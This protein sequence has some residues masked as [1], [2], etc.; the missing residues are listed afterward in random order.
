MRRLRNRPTEPTAP[1]STTTSAGDP[2]IVAR[3]V[4]PLLA[5]RASL[6]TGASVPDATI[7]SAL[8]AASA[9]AAETETPHRDGL[10]AIESTMAGKT[11][12]AAV[13]AMRTTQTQIGDISDRGPA[14]L[15]VL[16][17]AQSTSSRAAKKVDQIIADFRSDAKVI[18]NN[19]NSSPDTDAVI[20]RATQALRDAIGTVT[21]ARTEMDDHTR[22]L[23]SMDP[24]TVTT[25]AG[26]ERNGYGTSDQYGTG[27]GTGYGTGTG[28]VPQAWSPQGQYG[29]MVPGQVPG[30]PIDP[31]LAAQ[32]QLQQQLIS[33]G[34]QIGT[35]AISAGVD[36]GTHLIDK[37]AEVGTHAM[38]TVA[39]SA[40]KAITEAINPG[41]AD[42][43]STGGSGSGKLFDFG[44]TGQSGQSTSPS[45]TTP[46]GVVIP[47]A[48]GAPAGPEKADLKAAPA[49]PATPPPPPSPVVPPSDSSPEAAPPAPKPAAPDHVP[50]G[51]AGGLALPPPSSGDQDHKPRG[52]GQLGVTV[53]AMVEETVPAAVIGDFGDDTL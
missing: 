10:H 40:D 12:D 29:G 14:Y 53:P 48:S 30:Q 33:A 39:A 13:P 6:G 50:P 42:G 11:S 20:T 5:L 2:P 24:L 28:T 4:E 18:L 32:M 15:A 16:S 45:G 31:A 22:R 17:D 23:D 52:E 1:A 8:S 27:T 51:A 9:R 3:L 26:L 19:A 25:P 49:A 44:G 46:G 43:A 21:A 35:S 7:A 34:V 38:D 41:A 36:I 47:P 37:I